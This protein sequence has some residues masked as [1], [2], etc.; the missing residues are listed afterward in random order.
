MILALKDAIRYFLQ[1]AHCAANCLQ[2]IHS[3]G[4]G[5]IVCK[6][7]AAHRAIITCN[8]LCTTWYEGTAQLL[9]LTEFKSH[10][11]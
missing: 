4:A 8:M 9:S 10:L 6:S 2:H 7:R 5:A 3:S 1:S 11:F